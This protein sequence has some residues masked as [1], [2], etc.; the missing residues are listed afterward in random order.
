VRTLTLRELN[1][2]TLARQLLLAREPLAVGAALERLAGLQAQES[3]APY[4]G[5]WARLAG[6]ERAELEEA[7]LSRA[8]VRAVLMR[9]TIH[10]V[11]LAD[12]RL[13]SAALYGD[14][15]SPLP[16]AALALGRRFAKRTRAFVGTTTRTRAE[17]MS[18][19]AT[20][21]G[22]EEAPL[23]WYALRVCADIVHAPE[24][25]LWKGKRPCFVA[26][27]E[28]PAPDPAAARAGLVRG[29]LAAFGPATVA[30]IGA[31]AGLRIRDVRLAVAAAEPFE[32]YADEQG[33]ELLDLPGAPL[34]AAETPAPAR[35]LPRWDNVILAHADRARIIPPAYRQAMSLVGGADYQCFLVDGFVGG[36]WRL[37]R[38][39]VVLEPFAPL[40]KPAQRELAGEAAALEAFLR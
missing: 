12:C 34:P 17:L 5:F 36:R 7:L 33:R 19:F 23:H 6:F 24:T 8:A 21:H 11:T 40:S 32:R 18:W 39:K 37:E 31:W 30:D 4:I 1:R 15:A 29:Y 10:L 13:M 20:T 14:D 22:F 27:D 26:L 2:A 25:G 28:A 16:P 35:L 9:N 3:K 38:G